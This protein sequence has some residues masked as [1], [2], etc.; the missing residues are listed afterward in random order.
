MRSIA[1]FFLLLF[2]GLFSVNVIAQQPGS[3]TPIL[4]KQRIK[5]KVYLSMLAKHEIM[6][7]VSSALVADFDAA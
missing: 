6:K 1:I 5:Y 3:S 2:A 7:M 4:E